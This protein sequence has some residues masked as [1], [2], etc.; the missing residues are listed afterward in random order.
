MSTILQRVAGGRALD[1][2]LV[3]R[4]APERRDAR[5]QRVLQRLLV[6]VG[7]DQHLLRIG[8]LHH[9]RQDRRTGLRDLLQL[10]EIE[11]QLASFF[12]LFHPK[13]PASGVVEE[14]WPSS[15]CAK[16]DRCAIARR[17]AYSGC[18]LKLEKFPRAVSRRAR[19]DFLQRHAAQLRDLLGD[20]ARVGRLAT[21]AAIGRGREVGA[22][23]LDHELVERRHPA[24]WPAPAARS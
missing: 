13:M 23:G 11:L 6:R 20:A 17:W 16:D 12:E 4:G 3:A 2:Q 14:K 21:L 24:R 22:I 19:G 7:H 5:L 15:N 9:H 8:V 10:R 1:P 18:L